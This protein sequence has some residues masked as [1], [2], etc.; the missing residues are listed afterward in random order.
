MRFLAHEWHPNRIFFRNFATKIQ[1][2]WSDVSPA[3][4]IC[5]RKVRAAQGAPLPKIEAIGDSR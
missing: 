5:R 2:Q 4:W 1:E 3:Y